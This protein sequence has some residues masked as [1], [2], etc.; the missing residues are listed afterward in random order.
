MNPELKGEAEILGHRVELSRI[1]NP[2]LRRVLRHRCGKDFLF[3]YGDA[4]HT[5][6]IKKGS[7]RYKEAYSDHR[8]YGD[9]T[10][11]TEKKKYDDYSDHGEYREYD[12]MH[13]HSELGW[14]E[15]S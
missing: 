8:E 3:G 12:D 11:H 7:P 15:G 6:S 13:K 4:D 1:K 9:H 5:E 10:D 14:H 2:L